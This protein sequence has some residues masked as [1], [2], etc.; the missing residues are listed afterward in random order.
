MNNIILYGLMLYVIVQAY[1]YF[2]MSHVSSFDLTF[3]SINR[4]FR[5]GLKSRHVDA[6]I[7]WF[8]VALTPFVLIMFYV[9]IGEFVKILKGAKV[10][11]PLC[12]ATL[13]GIFGVFINFHI[14]N[15]LFSVG[16]EVLAYFFVV[17][18]MLG[19]FYCYISHAWKFFLYPCLKSIPSYIK[20]LFTDQESG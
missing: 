20:Y 17:I 18:F 16:N 7:V 4:F 3:R 11:V 1:T 15:Y 6:Y 12:L 5:A 8:C 19:C 10:S 14:Y 2:L 13:I 9:I